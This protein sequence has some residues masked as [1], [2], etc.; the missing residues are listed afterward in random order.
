MINAWL[1]LPVTGIFASLMIAYGATAVVIA[2]LT[3]RSPLRGQIQRCSGIVAPYFA[4]IALLFSLLTGFLA[5]DVIDRFKQGVRAVQTEA[6]AL[7]SLDALIRAS[8]VDAEPIRKALV[9]YIRT[10]VGDEWP[11]MSAAQTSTQAEAALA[12]LLRAIA[13]PAIAPAAG[14]A[15]QGGLIQLGLQ[16]ATAR[17]DRIA[18][19]TSHADDIKWTTVLLLCLMTQISIGMVHLERAR[20]QIA[21]LTIFTIAAVI[22]LGMI[23]IQE[24]PFDGP[25]QLPPAPLE[26]ALKTITSDRDSAADGGIGTAARFVRSR[27]PTRGSGHHIRGP[28]FRTRAVFRAEAI[29]T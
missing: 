6:G 19:N 21:S 22:A 23:A 12:G 2:W 5:G 10:L 15:V 3:F 20:A 26:R 4:S 27:T 24:A 1:D 25:L 11:K 13:D 7:S 14:T 28:H 17:S 16:A 9:I 29:R 18:L 8:A